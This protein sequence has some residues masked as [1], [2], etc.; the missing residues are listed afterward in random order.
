MLASIARQIKARDDG[1]R[2]KRNRI[3]AGGDFDLHRAGFAAFFQSRIERSG[4]SAIG[5]AVH[6]LFL[7]AAIVIAIANG[8]AAIGA[9]AARE[10]NLDRNGFAGGN[11]RGRRAVDGNLHRLRP[12]FAAERVKQPGERDVAKRRADED[13][14]YHE[15]DDRAGGDCRGLNDR[16]R[17]DDRVHVRLA[18]AISRLPHDQLLHRVGAGNI[19]ARGS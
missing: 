11:A 18:H 4:I 8:D 19:A 13:G 6:H 1:Q 9:I 7:P 2:R 5:A 16:A 14:E 17:V 15:T 10:A 12:D 3:I